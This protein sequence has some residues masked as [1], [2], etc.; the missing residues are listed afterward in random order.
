MMLQGPSS[1]SRSPMRCS[2]GPPRELREAYVPPYHPRPALTMA[3]RIPIGARALRARFRRTRLSLKPWGTDPEPEPS[4]GAS[5]RTVFVMKPDH[6]H[7]SDWRA[8]EVRV[9]EVVE[10]RGHR[11]QGRPRPSS[12]GEADGL[13]SCKFGGLAFAPRPASRL[14]RPR[15]LRD[16][17]R[18][19]L[20]SYLRARASPAMV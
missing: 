19:R 10:R 2:G 1:Q 13:K 18:T 3:V 7:T 11:D 14:Q 17:A 4:P 16:D 12:A 15:V 5:D 6:A 8:C 20:G 9:V